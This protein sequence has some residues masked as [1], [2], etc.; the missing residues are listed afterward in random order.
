M[1]TQKTVGWG[2]IGAST[3]A[4]EHMVAAIRAQTGHEV[5]AVH[6]SSQSRAAVFAQENAIP[7]AYSDLA[8]LLADHAVNAVNAVYFSTTNELHYDQV[9]AA[10]PPSSTWPTLHQISTDGSDGYWG[11]LP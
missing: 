2:L 3:I 1:S 10:S 7:N 11:G 4:R 8:A 5:V 9:L 6:S